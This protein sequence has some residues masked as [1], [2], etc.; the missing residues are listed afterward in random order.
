MSGIWDISELGGTSE[1]RKKEM[2]IRKGTKNQDPKAKLFA[3]CGTHG[4]C[5]VKAS[6]GS[7]S[8][9]RSGSSSTAT[10]GCGSLSFPMP[11][12]RLETPLPCTR[13]RS[14][15]E[16]AAEQPGFT[17]FFVRTAGST[18]RSSLN[19]AEVFEQALKRSLMA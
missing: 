15:P 13:R 6:V 18:R 17:L 10:L 7:R 11:Q 14:G 12:V 5:D 8:S 16:R 9:S 2:E 19:K 3:F 1:V 4:F